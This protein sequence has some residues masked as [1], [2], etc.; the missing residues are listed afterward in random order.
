MTHLK[1][2]GQ[3]R[4]FVRGMI[5]KA[6]PKEVYKIYKCTEKIMHFKPKRKC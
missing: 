3:R 2:T 4:A 5:L 1:T 6:K